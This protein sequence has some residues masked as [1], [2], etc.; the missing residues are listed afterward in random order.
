MADEPTA[1]IP[2]EELVRAYMPAEAAWI[3]GDHPTQNPDGVTVSNVDYWPKTQEEKAEFL[4]VAFAAP[5]N[6]PENEPYPDGQPLVTDE[7]SRQEQL[8]RIHSPQELV[9]AAASDDIHT[10]NLAAGGSVTSEEI[11]ADAASMQKDE[12]RQ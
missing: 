7:V 10:R 2:P 11:L 12:P 3:T 6:V 4:G 9:Q 1:P 5:V 8:L